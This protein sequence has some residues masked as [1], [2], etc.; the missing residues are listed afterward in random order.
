MNDYYVPRNLAALEYLV[1]HILLCLDTFR[2]SSCYTLFFSRKI[3]ETVICLLNYKNINY[4]EIVADIYQRVIWT[5]DVICYY[6]YSVK[7]F[8][9][10]HEMYDLGACSTCVLQSTVTR[11]ISQLLGITL[12][13]NNEN[14]CS[15][16]AAP[17]CDIQITF[18]FV[19]H[20]LLHKALW[21]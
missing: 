16:V 11:F 5:V 10:F 8:L 4:D 18:P 2:F 6:M 20:M 17:S 13:I 15:A 1:L 9:S 7:R 3:R 14:Q 19:L 21:L 12:I